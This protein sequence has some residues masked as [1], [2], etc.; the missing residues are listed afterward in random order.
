MT[1]TPRPETASCVDMSSWPDADQS[2]AP[3]MGTLACKLGTAVGVIG[4]ADNSTWAGKMP[5]G[6]GR[7]T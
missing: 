1:F 2:A 6:D 7:K 4:A 3:P 5:S